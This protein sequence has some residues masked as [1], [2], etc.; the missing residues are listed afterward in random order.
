MKEN[1][2]HKHS[3]NG[4]LESLRSEVEHLRGENH[5]LYREIEEYQHKAR[6]EAAL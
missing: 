5:L 6:E 3:T 1:I 4:E 2:R